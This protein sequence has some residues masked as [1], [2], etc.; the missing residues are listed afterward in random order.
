MTADFRWGGEADV[1]PGVAEPIADAA[2]KVTITDPKTMG[3]TLR[4]YTAYTVTLSTSLPQYPQKMCEVMRRYSEFEWLHSRICRTYPSAIIP[5]F[6]GKKAVGGMDSSFIHDRMRQ[7]EAYVDACARHPR[8]SSSYDLVVFLTSS[9]S[10]LK[11]AR[12]YASIAEATADE[13]DSLYNQL[14][15]TAAGGTPFVVK[16]DDDFVHLSTFHSAALERLRAVSAVSTQLSM[17]CHAA[18]RDLLDL[19]QAIASLAE[20][21]EQGV[22]AGMSVVASRK[23]DDAQHEAVKRLA[24]TGVAADTSGGPTG[25][26]EA[27]SSFAAHERASAAG[28]GQPASIDA[29]FETDFDDPLA[30][31]G[32]P[33]AAGLAKSKGAASGLEDGP[34][35]ELAALYRLVGDT[36]IRLSQLGRDHIDRSDTT[37]HRPI[38]EE[39]RREAELDLAAK[40]REAAVE[41]L[42]RAHALAVRRK[43]AYAALASRG[44]D[45]A[46]VAKAKWD[47]E[48]ADRG[49]AA[50]DQELSDI[51][52]SLKQE[53][54]R[55]MKGRRATLARCALEYVKVLSATA[56]VR[57][58]GWQTVTTSLAGTDADA[59]A[60]ARKRVVSYA[61]RERNAGVSG[62]SDTRQQR[63]EAAEGARGAAAA[64]LA[65]ARA[66][67]AEEATPA[68][69]PATPTPASPAPVSTGGDGAPEPVP[70]ASEDEF[71]D[72]DADTDEVAFI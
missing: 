28:A 8:I 12:E 4:S 65:G 51:T 62:V 72:A 16:A 50:R 10:S 66:R 44:G 19:G 59:L 20:Q 60:A 21:E 42:Q 26:V 40:R 41:A 25:D 55:V 30:G 5:L 56:K 70:A 22:K 2:I 69:A 67:A 34:A 47:V 57:R 3:G 63:R 48:R 46:K 15:S 45:P 61:K 31:M 32:D 64:G 27:D 24:G 18:E 35:A 1:S 49:K 52:E 54:V 9:A 53:M 6:P 37:L 13:A 17:G 38:A 14:V 68:Q 7:L 36:S 58:E 33:L 43:D 71:A 23:I 29:M 11:A 39:Q